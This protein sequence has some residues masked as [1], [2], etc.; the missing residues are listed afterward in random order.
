M[1]TSFPASSL[2]VVCII[3]NYVPTLQLPQIRTP[4]QKK[5]CGILVSKQDD[6]LFF[7]GQLLPLGLVLD[8][9]GP[10]AELAAHTVTRDEASGCPIHVAAS[11]A[12]HAPSV[13]FLAAPTT[14]E[15]A[16]ELAEAR[17]ADPDAFRCVRRLLI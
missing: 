1:L 4:K 12:P 7:G 8:D 14:P 16:A 17:A 10:S 15:A 13:A 9:L 3:T 11:S 2:H 6:E 5:H